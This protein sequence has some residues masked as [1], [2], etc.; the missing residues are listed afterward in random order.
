MP[1]LSFQSKI[2]K[3]QVIFLPNLKSKM[4]SLH[5]PKS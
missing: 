4:R 5:A 3:V 1:G 2:P